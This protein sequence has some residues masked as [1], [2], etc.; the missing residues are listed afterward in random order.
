MLEDIKLINEV[1][2]LAKLN[3]EDIYNYST[4]KTGNE[5]KNNNFFKSPKKN[6]SLGPDKFS[7]EF[8][9]PFDSRTNI[10]TPQ[11]V[12]CN[13]K[14]RNATKTFYEVIII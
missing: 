9:L 10:N 12:P 1:S 14:E 8:Y 11:I 2:D 4:T 3:K 6:K 13:K 7:A 5:I